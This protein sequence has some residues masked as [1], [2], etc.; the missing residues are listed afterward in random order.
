MAEGR[1]KT[2]RQYTHKTHAKKSKEYSSIEGKL[3]LRTA[4]SLESLQNIYIDVHNQV[5]SQIYEYMNEL[6]SAENSLIDIT[7]EKAFLQITINELTDYLRKIRKRILNEMSELIKIFNEKLGSIYK[8]KESQKN[9]KDMA[10]LVKKPVFIVKDKSKS[11]PTMDCE[12]FNSTRDL[13]KSENNLFITTKTNPIS[14]KITKSLINKFNDYDFE[15]SD[16]LSNS[17]ST[18]SKEK[19]I[20]TNEHL[21]EDI[22]CDFPL[23]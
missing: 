2:K 5:I 1:R 8:S 16:F 22:W 20:S 18:P 23:I 13:P 3:A 11:M 15:I 19:F 7:M 12:L 9:R 10:E 4:V 6:N 14:T 17:Q 21:I